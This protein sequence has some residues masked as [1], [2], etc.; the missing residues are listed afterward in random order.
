MLRHVDFLSDDPDIP[1]SEADPITGEGKIAT[2]PKSEMDRLEIPAFLQ[3]RYT[4][5]T[6]PPAITTLRPWQADLFDTQEWR[7]RQNGLI[8]IPTAGGKTV[9]AEV[10][11][12]Q[13]LDRDRSAKVIYCL[14]FVSLAAEKYAEFVARFPDFSVR[15]FYANI[16]GPEFNCGSIAIATYEKA[17]ALINNAQ[18]K[19]CLDKIA[20]VIIDEIHM[21]GDDSRG[22]N[23]EALVAKLKLQAKP[24]ILGLSATISQA[25]AAVIGTW[26]GGFVFQRNE[27][28]S[29]ITQFVLT[30]DGR[31][32]R[33]ADGRSAETVVRFE[34]ILE[35]RTRLL[36]AIASSFQ[37][38][39]N[40]SV[41]LFVN[42]RRDTRRI[43]KLIAL[44][45]QTAPPSP[46]LV[47]ARTDLVAAIAATRMVAD[48]LMSTCLMCGV[49]F[50]HAGLLLEERKLIE[51]GLRHGTI[52]VVVATTTLSAGIN[53][54][55]VSTVIIENVYR[56]EPGRVMIPLT[57]SQ[58]CQMAGRAGRVSSQAG[59][60][61]VVQHTGDEKE[62]ALIHSLSRGEPGRLFG[63]LF[64]PPDL[65]RYWLQCL[66]FFGVQVAEHFA[67]ASF[68]AC[69]GQAT[70]LPVHIAESTERLRVHHLIDGTGRISPLGASIAAAN[71]GIG[72]G[73]SVY[74]KLNTAAAD[75]CF[76]DDL[77]LL[78]VCMPTEVVFA[79][80]PYRDDI[81][82]RLY[83]AHEHVFGLTVRLQP[84]EWERLITLSYVNCGEKNDGALDC[85]LDQFYGACALLAVIEE[86]PLVQVEREFKIERGTIES[87]QTATA[88]LAGQICKFCEVC[89]KAVLG[90][91]INKFR[92]RLNYAVKNE[93][94]ALM[95]IPSCTR[96]VARLLFDRGVEDPGDLLQL[97]VDE[98][99]A[100]IG[101]QQTSQSLAERLKSEAQRIWDFRQHSQAFIDEAKLAHFPGLD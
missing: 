3:E 53:I 34:S 26:L 72:D 23:V 32:T 77:H 10:A 88:T 71:L 94:I 29:P 67:E 50:H 65:D 46:A 49:A 100:L 42:T 85:K 37:Q 27:R 20:L 78:Y 101:V 35:D 75:C 63:H 16:G 48:D 76:T 4:A 54:V 68:V 73:L 79:T 70:D 7:E 5:G 92:Q 81:W 96:P 39:E 51:R 41:L 18:R 99:A 66:H 13:L 22:A 43:A 80:P 36:P 74:E 64:D 83:R 17:H 52:S 86:R 82:T 38:S 58:Y 91:A 59:R 31:L 12:A 21:I 8:L 6:P 87:L 93:L 56:T 1:S 11:I 2:P 98:I 30:P 62:S 45:L 15:P 33:L 90:A 69:S 60:V 25:D 47:S 57:P 24:Q 19:K 14:P 9:V 84:R 89:G 55:S 44:H 28:P 61:I 40:G 97:S 95:A